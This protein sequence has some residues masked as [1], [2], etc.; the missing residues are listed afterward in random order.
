[1]GVFDQAARLATMA[2]PGFVLARLRPLTGLELIWRR[3]FNVKGV[4]L[5]AG[6][7]READLVAVVDETGSSKPPWLLI[8]EVQ[9]Q[10][11]EDK[12][13]V[14]LVEASIFLCYARDTDRDGGLFQALPV[15][16]YLVGKCP[17]SAVTVRTPTGQGLECTPAVWEVGEDSAAQ[18]LVKVEA[19]EFS[20][21]ALF[22]VSLMK[23]ADEE[24]VVR[25]WQ[26]LRD[27][28]VPE[29]HR[30]DVTGI[31]LIF[32]RLAGCWLA[33]NRVL[34]G[35]EMTESDAVNELLE[36]YALSTFR[37]ALLRVIKGRLPA[38]VTPDVERAIKDQPSLALL[39]EWLDAA[40]TSETAEDFLAVL[41]R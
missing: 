30:A 25:H 9:S 18:T 20:W 6:P 41:R 38:A 2:G 14:L 39:E 36:E 23:G 32:A 24:D 19:G 10:H 29:K 8:F 5:P 33:W 35:I 1:M 4:P 7:D 15:F 27:E 37:K 11:D 34:G 26:R 28:K 3:W 12:P 31:A 21:E 40:S 13:R 22:W 16:V 17:S